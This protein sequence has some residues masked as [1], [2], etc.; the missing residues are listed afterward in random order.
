MMCLC[1]KELNGIKESIDK[2]NRRTVG[3]NRNCER[4]GGCQEVDSTRRERMARNSGRPDGRTADQ[5]RR[6]YARALKFN[7]QRKKC[8]NCKEMKTQVV[9]CRSS[10][11]C[12]D[13]IK[14]I[15]ARR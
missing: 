1:K 9:R 15:Q 10:Q 8:S 14:E 11:I 7:T 12:Q 13:C 3:G 2:L 4:E 5:V 6:F